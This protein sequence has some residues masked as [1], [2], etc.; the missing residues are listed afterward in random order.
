MLSEAA[1]AKLPELKNLESLA[2]LAELEG[3]E[4]LAKLKELESLQALEALADIDVRIETEHL[5]DNEAS[6]PQQKHIVIKRSAHHLSSADDKIATARAQIERAHEQGK[7]SAKEKARLL[8]QLD[9]SQKQVARSQQQLEKQ[10][11]AI[12][13]KID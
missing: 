2:T 6:T 5:A 9:A 13:S 12:E 11:R 1:L 10:L 7:L 8:K 4:A 3:L